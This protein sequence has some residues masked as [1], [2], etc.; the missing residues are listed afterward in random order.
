M[1]RLRQSEAGGTAHALLPRA[2]VAYID[3]SN[4]EDSAEEHATAD[5]YVT[6]WIGTKAVLRPDVSLV[7]ILDADAL[8][9]RPSFP[10]DGAGLSS[11][12]RDVRLGGPGCGWRAI[13][14]PGERA[15]PLRHPSDHP[16]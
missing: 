16:W 5:I 4:V 15:R 13:G 12:R 1:D 11:V 6:T 8:I 10:S 9:R 3:P 2:R 14:D 7:G